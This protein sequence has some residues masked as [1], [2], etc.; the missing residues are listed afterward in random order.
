MVREPANFNARALVCLYC[1]TFETPAV[2]WDSGWRAMR[3]HLYAEHRAEVT[4][5]NAPWQT[6][7]EYYSAPGKEVVT[8]HV[9]RHFK[10]LDVSWSGQDTGMNMLLTDRRDRRVV[11]LQV[12][13]SN[14]VRFG[15]PE[16]EKHLRACGYW[17]ID[18]PKLRYS[19]ADYWVLVL[20]GFAARSEDYVVIVPPAE[21]WRRLQNRFPEYSK[22]KVFLW[23]TEDER[24]W[25]TLLLSKDD[26]HRIFRGE[27][28]EPE[29][30]YTE[31]LNN[32]KPIAGLDR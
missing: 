29:R 3:K 24:C 9:E 5:A 4:E 10:H 12:E 27:Y 16:Y 19:H 26:E 32:W 21:L 30:E 8:A 7:P 1:D 17:N 31:W 25:D 18:R 6:W 28:D 13:T 14:D 23:V 22:V 11:A 2:D 20:Q 15:S